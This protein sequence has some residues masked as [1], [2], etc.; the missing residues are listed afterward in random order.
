[1]GAQN[2]QRQILS[3]AGEQGGERNRIYG[4]SRRHG[5]QFGDCFANRSGA[6]LPGR[7]VKVD[8]DGD[9]VMLAPYDMPSMGTGYLWKGIT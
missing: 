4:G 5:G 9:E 7:V 8:L 2:L 6:M 3:M 1:M